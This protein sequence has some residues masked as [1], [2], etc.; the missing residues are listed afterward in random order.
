MTA[1]LLQTFEGVPDG[2]AISVANSG[3]APSN[4][5]GSI[6]GKGAT[7][8]MVVDTVTAM[9]GTKSLLYTNSAAE[10]NY[11]LWTLPENGL[12]N[13]VS[14]YF[15]ISAFPAVA[16]YLWRLLNTSSG[17]IASLTITAA[18]RLRLLGSGAT[19]PLSTVDIPLNTWCRA[20]CRTIVG[21]D[22]VTGSLELKWF[23]GDGAQQDAPAIIAN[24][25]LGI[26]AGG[27]IRIGRAASV[28]SATSTRIDSLQ[29]RT[30][31]AGLIGAYVPP[32]SVTL[33]NDF[34]GLR[35]AGYTG[36]LSDMRRQNFL[37]LLSLTEPQ[38]TNNDLE[39]RYYRS[40]GKT[41]SL[42][43]ARHQP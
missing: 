37:A 5:V 7:S 11:W 17:V 6:A 38:G 27:S 9:H 28:A 34:A 36:S 26:L 43:D 24:E 1:N 13:S 33:I 15:R 14:I 19:G 18:G 32:P 4:A 10:A 23:L 12:S 42:M 22:T 2:A 29:V 8:S 31:S 41:G 20:D 16:D 35:A 39:L 30:N 25:N 21:A 40:I 3:T